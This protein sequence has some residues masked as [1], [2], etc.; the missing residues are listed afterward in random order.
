ML[1]MGGRCDS[2][3]WNAVAFVAMLLI[4][5]CASWAGKDRDKAKAPAG[6]SLAP[7]ARIAVAP[8]GFLAPSPAYLHLRTAWSTLNFIDKDHLLFTFHENRLLRRAPG[9]WWEDNGQVIHAEVLDISRGKVLR[10]ADWRMYDRNPYLWALRDGK[11]LVRKKSA[12]YLTDSSLELKPYLSFETE[13]QAVEISP[14]RSMMAVELKKTLPAA[15]DE[16]P[17]NAP[18]L[19]TPGEAKAEK[20]PQTRTEVMMVRPGD[21]K[22]LATG[23]IRIPQAVPLAEDGVLNMLQGHDPKEWVIEMQALGKKL[24]PVGEMRSDCPP[25][26]QMLSSDVMLARACPADGSTDAAVKVMKIGGGELWEDRW[27]SR[28]IWPTFAFAEN[29]SRFAY[30]S[31]Q[32]N[33]DIGAMDSFGEAD[34]VAQPVGVF[35]T[36]TGKLVLVENAD[37]IL[38]EGQNYAL[39]ADGRR[40]AILRGAA[41]EV[42]DLPPVEKAE[43]KVKKDKK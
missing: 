6:P 40:F 32:A 41:I 27:A 18:S 5:P 31:L 8:L 24:K 43:V 3:S 11:F 35:D 42:Y 19:L 20:P 26:L 29:G 33:R 28:Y 36:E 7:T 37:P 16:G 25:Q 2:R 10:Q 13:L 14:E 12:L 1:L 22:A 34:I 15:K 17:A 39:S 23:E 9:E 38:S 21:R 30:G 4:L